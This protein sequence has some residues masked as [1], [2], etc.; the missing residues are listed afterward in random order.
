M[1]TTEDIVISSG[2][3][4]RLLNVSTSTILRLVNSGVLSCQRTP[5]GH[6]RFLLSDIAR[7]QESLSRG[8]VDQSSGGTSS[9]ALPEPEVDFW[10]QSEDDGAGNGTG[11]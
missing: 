5:N 7:Y 9:V 3:A 10:G 4:A 8:D 1:S 11:A 2:Q 6:S